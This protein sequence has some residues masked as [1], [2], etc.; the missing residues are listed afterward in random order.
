MRG[1]NSK[2]FN[3]LFNIINN[4]K[5]EDL[6]PYK[7]KKSIDFNNKLYLKLSYDNSL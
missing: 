4:C 7:D 2:L 1:Y 3:K 5:R 6:L